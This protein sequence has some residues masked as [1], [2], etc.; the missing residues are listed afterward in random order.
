MNPTI[1][2]IMQRM[3]GALVAAKAEGVDAVVHFKFTGV[4]AGEWNAIIRDGE[5]VVAQGIPK[6]RPSVTLTADSAA[7]VRVLTGDLDATRAVMEGQLKI[8][9]DVMLATR[10]VQLFKIDGS[11]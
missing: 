3:P 6:S 2:E 10:L 11:R 8:G 9:G 7:F 4:E 5:C 1:A